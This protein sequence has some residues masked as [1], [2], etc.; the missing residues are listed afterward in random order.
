VGIVH[1]LE[2]LYSARCAL[3]LLKWI[4]GV[5]A[6]ISLEGVGFLAYRLERA[7]EPNGSRARVF[8]C[9]EKKGC[10]YL[11]LRNSF[12]PSISVTNSNL[13]SINFVLLLSRATLV[14]SS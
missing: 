13:A 9:I 12:V 8:F 7:S 14:C 11:R 3:K 6:D 4:V 1:S 10:C 2:S 5:G